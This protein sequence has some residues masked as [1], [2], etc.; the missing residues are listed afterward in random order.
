MTNSQVTINLFQQFSVVV[1]VLQYFHLINRNVIE[2]GQSLG[3]I[4][5]LFYKHSIDILHIG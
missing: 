5:S 3:L 1:F 2:F 4:Y